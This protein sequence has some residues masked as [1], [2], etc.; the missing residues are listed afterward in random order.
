M[1][2]RN[3]ATFLWVK[4]MLRTESTPTSEMVLSDGNCKHPKLAKEDNEPLE[5]K[6][7]NDIF[8]IRFEEWRKTPSTFVGSAN[9][10]FWAAILVRLLRP[11]GGSNVTPGEVN[12]GPW[13]AVVDCTFCRLCCSG[14]TP[15]CGQTQPPFCSRRNWPN[16]H[17]TCMNSHPP[18]NIVLV[19]CL[20]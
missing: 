3:S 11:L 16:Q 13:W 20:P 1:S 10:R 4:K 19:Q 8:G 5:P 2:G 9:S 6:L 15:F 18:Y 14:Q 17:D 7:L 12:Q